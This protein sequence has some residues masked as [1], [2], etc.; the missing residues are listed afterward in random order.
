MVLIDKQVHYNEMHR[1]VWKHRGS[2]C[3]SSAYRLSQKV[4]DGYF[5]ERHEQL[6]L[7]STVKEI[8]KKPEIGEHSSVRSRKKRKLIAR[9]RISFSEGRRGAIPR[10]LE[11]K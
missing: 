5:N 9:A 8:L 10:E 1:K 3:S 4:V 2:R 7:P 6:H 11:G